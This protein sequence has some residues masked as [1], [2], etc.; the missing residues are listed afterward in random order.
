[1][2]A[3]MIVKKSPNLGGSEIKIETARGADLLIPLLYPP[4]GKPI[5]VR[6]FLDTEFEIWRS[7]YVHRKI[8]NNQFTLPCW[9][10]K[11]CPVCRRLLGFD[12]SW[13]SIPDYSRS[14]VGFCY[15][16][17][18]RYDGRISHVKSRV[19]KLVV[20][21]GHT[22]FL[23]AL[24]KTILDLMNKNLKRFCEFCDHEKP[25]RPLRIQYF[26]N[27]KDYEVVFHQSYK[28]LPSYVPD[29]L[30]PLSKLFFE[31]DEEPD[32]KELAQYLEDM[33]NDH[34]RWVLKR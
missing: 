15:A 2:N 24:N 12:Q 20:L 27:K 31:K 34:T 10:R 3:K 11:A 19:N 29:Y 32:P 21:Y 5:Y 9:D 30:P 18:C 16:W 8:P 13:P 14:E 23:N 26:Y 25:F 28:E 22:R 6:I 7:I 4:H 33:E 17:L 1:M